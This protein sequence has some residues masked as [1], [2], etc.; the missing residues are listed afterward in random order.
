MRQLTD[1]S[2]SHLSTRLTSLEN[3]NIRGCKQVIFTNLVLVYALRLRFSAANHNALLVYVFIP[4][5]L[6]M[7]V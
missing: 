7:S 4:V 3:L 1:A 6:I 5:G 2:I